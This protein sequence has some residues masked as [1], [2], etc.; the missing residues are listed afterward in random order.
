MREDC[1]IYGLKDAVNKR[2]KERARGSLGDDRFR[3]MPPLTH[4]RQ[5]NVCLVN[6]IKGLGVFF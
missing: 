2:E 1:N 6:V 5:G 4:R 3:E